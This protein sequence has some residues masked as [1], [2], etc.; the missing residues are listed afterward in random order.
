[1]SCKV[2]RYI[3]KSPQTFKVV[4]FVGYNPKLQ[5]ENLK[6]TLNVSISNP[7]DVSTYLNEMVQVVV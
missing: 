4:G 5:E 1:M 3:Q 6:V 2:L 7:L